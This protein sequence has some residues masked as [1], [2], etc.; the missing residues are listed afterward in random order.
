VEVPSSSR[1]AMR[2]WTK[3]SG[4]KIEAEFVK[5]DKSIITLR[6][7]DGTEFTVRMAH[8][9]DEDQQYVREHASSQAK[10]EK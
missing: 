4:E 6:K 5:K 1:A 8:L 9:S 10:P 2:G 3:T 7:P